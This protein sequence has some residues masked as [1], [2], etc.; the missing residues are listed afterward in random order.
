M[1]VKIVPQYV[2]IT[3]PSPEAEL[4]VRIN[5]GFSTYADLQSGSV[6]RILTGL[7]AIV[8]THPFTD[9]NDKPID[10]GAVPRETVTAIITAYTTALVSTAIPKA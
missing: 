7:Q 8:H 2:T 3:I 4:E 10:I 1:T 6:E 9:E 5:P